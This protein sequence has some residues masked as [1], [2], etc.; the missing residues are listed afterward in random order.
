[1]QL[2]NIIEIIS[3]NKVSAVLLLIIFSLIILL[4]LCLR[5]KKSKIVMNDESEN[6]SNPSSS[7]INTEDINELKELTQKLETLK[8]PKIEDEVISYEAEQEEK[9]IISYE[10]LLS[11]TQN[12]SISYS[13][14]ETNDDI[15]I[16]KVD[17][18]KTNKIELDPIKKELNSRVSISQYEHEEDFLNTLK[19]LQNLIN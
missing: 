18:E 7:E 12:V 4:L 2:N 13:E 8:K 16:K 6:E 3:E 14:S 15:T 19:Q 10:E 9:A 1:M 17:L 5:D 11:Q